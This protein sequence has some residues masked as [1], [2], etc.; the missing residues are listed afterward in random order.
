MVINALLA[1]LVH[2]LA[3]LRTVPSQAW[4]VCTFGFKRWSSESCQS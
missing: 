2:C 3:L 1:D 4:C